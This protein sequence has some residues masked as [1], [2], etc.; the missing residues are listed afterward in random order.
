[1]IRFGAMPPGIQSQQL[2]EIVIE[3][4]LQEALGPDASASLVAELLVA[5]GFP[6][7]FA[8]QAD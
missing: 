4:T 1:M 3:M 6:R 5:A 8:L 7:Q 2:P